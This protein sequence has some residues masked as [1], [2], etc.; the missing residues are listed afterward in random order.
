MSKEKDQLEFDFC[1]VACRC[2]E[3][4]KYEDLCPVCL[5]ECLEYMSASAVDSEDL[6]LSTGDQY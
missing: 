5:D 3:N 1:Q 6:D 2:T 4:T